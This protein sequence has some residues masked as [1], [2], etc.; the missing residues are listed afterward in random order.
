MIIC[1]AAMPIIVIVSVSCAS[2]AEMPK[3]V[4]NSGSAGRYIS[5]ES[6]AIALIMP[7]KSVRNRRMRFVNTINE[8]TSVTTISPRH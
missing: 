4:V 6:G 7:R 2:D 5:V 8:I 3:S 1:P